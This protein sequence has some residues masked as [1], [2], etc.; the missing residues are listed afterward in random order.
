MC[1]IVGLFVGCSA[2]AYCPR[3]ALSGPGA[4][5]AGAGGTEGTAEADGIGPAAPDPSGDESYTSPFARWWDRSSVR[6]APRRTL[7]EPSSE[8]VR[9][10]SPDL[11]PVAR[12]PLIAQLRPEVFDQVL[13]QHLYRYLDFTAKL[14]TLVVNRTVLGIAGGSVGVELPE[15]MRFDAYKIYCDEAYHAL[16]SVDLM[17]QVRDRTGIAPRLPAQPYFLRRLEEI[18][19]TLAPEHRALAELIFVTVSETLISAS[20]AEIPADDDVMPAVRDTIRDHAMDEGR[21]HAYFATFLRY[22]W[23]GLGRAERR[24]AALLAPRLIDAFLRPDTDAIR[25]ELLGYGL[26]RDSAEQVLAEVYDECTVAAHTRMTSKRTL[27]YFTSLDVLDDPRVE[28][29]FRT[30]GL[31]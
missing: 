16:F 5:T 30:Y 17:R 6:Q 13:I 28:Q 31:L 2:L 18:Q 24:Q 25:E 27:H 19:S 22:L 11:V 8:A 23:A 15:E 21:H 26:S 1:G 3:K 12:H 9:Y 10:F 29:E 7:D 4:P 20:L 14:E